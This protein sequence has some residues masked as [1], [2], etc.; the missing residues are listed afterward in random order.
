VIARGGLRPRSPALV[1]LFLLSAFS[2]CRHAPRSPTCLFVDDGW[3][4][5]GTTKLRAEVVVQGLVVPWS[6][7]FLPDG[8]LLVTERPGRVRL[9]SGGQLVETP[10]ATIGTEAAGEGGLQGL[11]LHPDFASNHLFYVYFTVETQQGKRNRL[12]RWRLAEGKR[13]AQFDAR[14]M[15]DLPAAQFHHG[16]RI[17][18]GPDGMLYVSVGDARDPDAAQNRDSP[19][20]KLHR[21][22][23]DGAP[24]PGNPSEDSTLFLLGLR[25]VEGFDWRDAQ[26]LVIADHGPSGE[27]LRTDHDEVS[28]AQKG[29][30][31]G[32]PTIYGCE[33][34]SGMISPSI[35]WERAA[36]PGGAAFYTADLIPGWKGSYVVGML[37]AKHLH[38]IV[39][40]D[41]GRTVASHE[42]YFQGEPPRGLGRLREV[43]MGPDGHLYV[44][45]SNC[46]GRGTCPPAMDQILR[47]LPAP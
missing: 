22:T 47:I 19:A 3:G 9:V 40:G 25:N 29:D 41:D 36:P 34:R 8:D 1:S 26:T 7:A 21:L 42:V 12:E 37:G 33:A 13:S 28:V 20:G 32:W 5:E 18:F 10:V 14:L 45:T 31:L 23:P 11:A 6:I 39:F 44:T 16:G 15:D 46:D 43:V 17:R 38:R 2:G 30:N 35:A 27:L 4:P 24:A